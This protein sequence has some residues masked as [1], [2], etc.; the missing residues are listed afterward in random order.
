MSEFGMGGP[1]TW[2]NALTLASQIFRDLRTLHTEAWIYW[3]AVENTSQN[4]WGLLQIPFNLTSKSITVSLQYW[5]LMHFTKTLQQDDQY[6][7]LNKNI[8]KITNKLTNKLAFVILNKSKK[9]LQLKKSFLSYLQ[10]CK[11]VS[12]FQ[13][14]HS[15]I[16][17]LKFDVPSNAPPQ[18][19]TSITLFA[20]N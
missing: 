11:L 14:T 13:S 15:K 12:C 7:F 2:S 1:N 10:T 8:L 16:M 19:I 9:S 6:V 3:Q 18:S 17:D 4:S 20:K 5:I